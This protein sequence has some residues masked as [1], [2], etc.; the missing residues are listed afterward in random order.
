MVRRWSKPSEVTSNSTSRAPVSSRPKME[1][2][3]VWKLLALLVFHAFG[4]LTWFVSLGFSSDVGT[5]RQFNEALEIGAAT[6]LVAAFLM[7]LLWWSSW[8]SPPFWAIPFVW[9]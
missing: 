4:A 6:W 2:R 7:L 5:D 9:W 3:R 1:A 8:K